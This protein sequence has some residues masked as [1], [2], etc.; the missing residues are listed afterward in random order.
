[1]VDRRF[2]GVGGGLVEFHVVAGIRHLGARDDK[3]GAVIEY[4]HRQFSP[5][6]SFFFITVLLSWR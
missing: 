1:M 5:S 3:T 2:H 6:S 4:V